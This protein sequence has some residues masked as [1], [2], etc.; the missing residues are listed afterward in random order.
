M[1]KDAIRPVLPEIPVPLQIA[2]EGE[3]ERPEEEKVA[4]QLLKEEQSL[5]LDRGEDR[6]ESKVGN[7][8]SRTEPRGAAG[9]MS[10]GC[11]PHQGAGRM[12]MVQAL[13][14]PMAQSIQPEWVAKLDNGAPRPEAQ[15][16]AWDWMTTGR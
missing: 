14:M 15:E 10:Q 3:R 9:W 13:V 12:S 11:R 1:R 8:V 4:K 2:S 5:G 7:K 6:L 16:T